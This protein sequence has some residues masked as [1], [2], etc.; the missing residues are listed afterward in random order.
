MIDPTNKK[1]CML[2]KCFALCIILSLSTSLAAQFSSHRATLP[3]VFP[4]Q[5][6][7]HPYFFDSIP[8]SDITPFLSFFLVWEGKADQFNV[9]FS[10][11]GSAWSEWQMVRRDVHNLEKNVSEL[12]ITQADY[13]FFQ[14]QNPPQEVNNIIAHFFSPGKSPNIPRVAKGNPHTQEQDCETIS[15]VGRRDWCPNGNCPTRSGPQFTEVSH[16]IVHHS[17]GTNN[18]NDWAAIVRAIYDL[19]VIGNGWADI[20]YNYLIDPDGIIYE[21]RGEDVLGAHFCARNSNTMGVCVMGNFQN[22][23]P[24]EEAVN[25]LVELLSWKAF[26]ENIDPIGKSLHPSSGLN[27]SHISGHRQGCGTA[28]PGN[29]FFPQM[30]DIR[31]R[32]RDS[33][34]VCSQVT[35]VDAEVDQPDELAVFPNPARNALHLLFNSPE[36]GMINGQIVSIEGWEKRRFS[37]RKETSFVNLELNLQNLPA[38]YYL[39]KME[40]NGK[41][42]IERFV[43]Y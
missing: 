32:V 7:E 9:R 23:S 34:L 19:H 12:F 28:C 36:T 10:T 27:L 13:R 17:A 35:A 3:V 1:N 21:G 38:G 18:A 15:I 41:S 30:N 39:C 11:D 26:K 31:E 37:F 33:L 22:Q 6:L 14:I 5:K 43:K 8:L 20:G 25:N 24:T 4:T 29:Q 42:W 2:I 40:L 16:L